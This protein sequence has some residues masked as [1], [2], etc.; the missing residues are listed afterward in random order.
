MISKRPCF[1]IFIIDS[2]FVYSQIGPYGW[3]WPPSMIFS[4]FD[5]LRQI[6]YIPGGRPETNI[7][8]SFLSNTP[9]NI[10]ILRG[11]DLKY[12]CIIG[13]SR[14]NENNRMRPTFDRNDVGIM[15]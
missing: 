6:P 1:V 4:I 8:S 5:K 9:A 12:G 7:Y 14:W 11:K 15:T 2:D 13:S 10:L 3:D